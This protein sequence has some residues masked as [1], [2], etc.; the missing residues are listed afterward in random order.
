MTKSPDIKPLLLLGGGAHAMV[1]AEAAIAANIP[2]AGFLDDDA[3][4]NLRNLAP[5]LGPISKLNDAAPEANTIIALGDVAIR[6]WVVKR[7]SRPSTAVVH[8]SAV[9]SPTAVLGAGVFVGPLAVIHA[10]ARVG[11]HAIIN[12]AAVIEH[13]CAIGINT[14]I[15]PGSVLGGAATV[16]PDSLL[17]LGC[18]VL[19]GARVGARAVVGAGSVVLHS[20]TDN[21]T[22]VG[23]PAHERKRSAF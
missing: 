8:P 20:V 5:H 4:A 6:A 19:P 7:L 9:V 16:G 22:V 11:D 2:L 13:D 17:G 21:T 10:R 15:A 23:V 18:R 1:V 12:T 14:H 3:D